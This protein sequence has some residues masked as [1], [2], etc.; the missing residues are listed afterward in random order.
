MQARVCGLC[1]RWIASGRA[2]G[3][4]SGLRLGSCVGVVSDGTSLGLLPPA[5]ERQTVAVDVDLRELAGAEVG[6]LGAAVAS[7]M[8]DA[9]RLAHPK[10]PAPDW[11]MCAVS[12]ARSAPLMP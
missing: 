5:V 9:W 7:R 10:R 8:Q 6:G 1:A 3:C 11:R 2:V 12:I 4:R